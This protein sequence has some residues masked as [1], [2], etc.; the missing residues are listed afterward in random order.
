VPGRRVGEHGGLLAP[1]LPRSRGHGGGARRQRAGDAAAPWAQDRQGGC[2][3]DRGALGAWPHPSEFYPT[4][5]YWCAAGSDAHAGDLDPEPRQANNRVIKVLEDTNIKLAS[6]VSDLFGRS[7]RRM[8]AALLAGERDPKTLAALAL[9]GLRRKQSQLEL[10]LTGQFTD[11]HAWLIQGALE[12]IDLLDRQIT[13]LDQHIGE[14]MAPLAPQLEQLTSIPG[15]EATAA[16]ASLAEIGTEMRHVMTRV[17]AS[18]AQ[19]A[20]AQGIATG[21]GYSCSVPGPPA[22]LLPSSATR[23]G[24]LKGAL[25]ARKRRWLSPIKFW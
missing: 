16:R 19:A 17:P 22:K 11:H 9:G 10:A 14:L 15:V 6:V 2:A 13:D 1:G 4:A 18:G 24:V 21:A 7:G 12:L 3:L 25:G 20:R 23:F 8:L 5:P